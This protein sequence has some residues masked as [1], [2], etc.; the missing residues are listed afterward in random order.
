MPVDGK[1][2]I[3][4]S[5]PLGSANFDLEI[6]LDFPQT[7][8]SMNQTISKG[9]SPQSQQLKSLEKRPPADD[10][11]RQYY[12]DINNRNYQSS[13]NKLSPKFQ[14]KASGYFGY[15]E[16]WN[17]VREVRIGDINLINQTHNNA[18]VHAELVYVMNTGKYFKDP[19][20]RIYLVWDENYSGWLFEDKNSIIISIKIMKIISH[21]WKT[22]LILSIVIFTGCS[23]PETP[24]NTIESNFTEPKSNLIDTECSEE[25]KLRLEPK[26]VEE[27]SLN[28]KTITKSNKVSSNKSI[29][30]TFQAE[31]GQK[32]NYQTDKDIC[33]WVYAPNNELVNGT[34]IPET[35][36][37]TIQIAVLK[38]STTFDLEMSLESITN[39]QASA[40]AVRSTSDKILTSDKFTTSNSSTNLSNNNL[41]QQQALSIVKGWYRAKP[42]MFAYPYDESLVDRYATGKLYYDTVEKDGGGSIGWLRRNGCYYTYDFSNIDNVWL[43]STSGM[44]PLLKVRVSER[45]QLNGSRS[46]GCS[47]RPRYYQKN[48]SYWF[49]KDNGDWKIY[50]YEV[51]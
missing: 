33:I 24:S 2:T 38:G 3:Q 37:Y 39:S 20:K 27:I 8:P 26:N 41:T 23:K 7:S 44:R 48:V 16:W 28:N 51:E 6:G 25:P 17:S 43:F 36:N 22:L 46:A 4:V 12:R 42:K 50:Y 1:Y 29:G 40:P 18:I 15:Q 14:R 19:K 31:A 30:Y 10:F 9:N 5:D 32:L 35:G 21:F 45:L 11:I 34:K 47:N 49:E 13:W